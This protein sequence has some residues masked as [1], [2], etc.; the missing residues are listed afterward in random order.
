[1]K[2]YLDTHLN[3]CLGTHLKPFL[4]PIWRQFLRPI[5]RQVWICIWRQVW[6]PIRRQIQWDPIWIQTVFKRHCIRLLLTRL[7]TW[8]GKKCKHTLT[9]F[10][11]G[12]YIELFWRGMAL[13]PYPSIICSWHPRDLK[14]ETWLLYKIIYL[15]K[16]HQEPL[17]SRYPTWRWWI[18]ISLMGFLTS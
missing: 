5:W 2:T 1:M 14:F 18:G 3:M 6:R 7:L 4:Q 12:F 15:Q 17:S 8:Q 11:K 9:L 13:V 10:L 16:V